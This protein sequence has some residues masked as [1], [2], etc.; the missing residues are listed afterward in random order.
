MHG[1]NE[2]LVVALHAN[3]DRLPLAGNEHI[4]GRAFR[5]VYLHVVDVDSRAVDNQR[6]RAI[7]LRRLRIA[8]CHERILARDHFD[9]I[10]AGGRFGIIHCDPAVVVALIGVQFRVVSGKVLHI[11]QLPRRPVFGFQRFAIS[12]QGVVEHVFRCVARNRVIAHPVLAVSVRAHVG[13]DIRNALIADLLS[14]FQRTGELKNGPDQ[15]DKPHH[16]RDVA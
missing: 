13:D 15:H 12:R 9:G 3:T 4:Q 7:A 1:G 6:Q 11:E 16:H 8:S 5:V 2:G 10:A 14:G